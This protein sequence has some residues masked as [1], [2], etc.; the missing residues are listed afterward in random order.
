MLR[1]RRGGHRGHLGGR[2]DP[3][4]RDRRPPAASQGRREHPDAAFGAS[5][6]DS[7]VGPP[8]PRQRDAA[9]CCRGWLPA[10]TGC[11][12]AGAHAAR[13]TPAWRRGCS[14]GHAERRAAD[15]GSRA[16]GRGCPGRELDQRCPASRGGPRCPAKAGDRRCPGWDGARQ[17]WPVLA[18]RQGPMP[19][20]ERASP[21]PAVRRV[22]ASQPVPSHDGRTGPGR[23]RP[24]QTGAGRRTR[25]TLLGAWPD[26]QSWRRPSSGCGICAR[27][28]L[29]RSRTPT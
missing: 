18:A 4:R 27:Q 11:C 21:E 2:P 3:V 8:A 25:R 5:C 13:R 24:A 1:D 19:P 7:G 16:A 10:C 14:P 6:P 20:P 17:T 15:R 9:A 29:R 22:R 12:R 26:L 28:G 23:T